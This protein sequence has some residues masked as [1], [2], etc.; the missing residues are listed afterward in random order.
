MKQCS[1]VYLYLGLL[2]SHMLGH[3]SILAITCLVAIVLAGLNLAHLISAASQPPSTIGTSTWNLASQPSY[4]PIGRNLAI[5]F[6]NNAHSSLQGVVYVIVRN[7]LGQTISYQTGVLTLGGGLSGTTYLP[8]WSGIPVNT[9]N[10]EISIFATNL[11]GVAISN[12]T[13]I[14]LTR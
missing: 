3:R 9:S 12:S 5:T 11:S 8:I 7:N 14:V 13:P 4:T 1:T 2:H 10:I 6:T